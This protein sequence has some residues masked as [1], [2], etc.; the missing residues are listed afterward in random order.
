MFSFCLLVCFSKIWIYFLFFYWP[1]F[2]KKKSK[3]TCILVFTD[4]SDSKESVCNMGELDSIPESERAPWEENGYPF[5][6]SCMENLMDRG[7][8]W[9]A[10]HRVA[11]SWAERLSN[12]ERLC[13]SRV[14]LSLLHWTEVFLIFIHV[15][16]DSGF[17][18]NSAFKESACSAGDS[19]SIPLLGRFLREGIGYPLQY[20]WVSLVAQMV[21]NPPAV[22]K[23][24]FQ[25]LGWEG[26]LE[27]GT[28]TYPSILSW[29]TAMD[30][31]A[32]QA[33]VHGSQRVRYVYCIFF[34]VLKFWFGM[35][36]FI[37]L[38]RFSV[39]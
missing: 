17:T 15:F 24:W 35:Y 34:S 31:G 13:F 30:R 39:F 36:L 14:W 12:L 7:T 32:C 23:T 28:A 22:Q 20:S 26:P 2:L 3:T 16:I 4:G 38:L 21:K 27:M 1:A 18:S 11:K 9:A 10:V 19:S 29:R 8:W 5:Q 6:Y 37:P 25:T 33:T